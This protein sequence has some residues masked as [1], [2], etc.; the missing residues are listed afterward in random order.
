MRSWCRNHPVYFMAGYLVFYLAFFFLLEKSVQV[1]DLVLHCTLDDLIPFCKYA[2][3]PYYAWFAW[4]PATLFFLLRRGPRW[5]F[6][7]LC[8]PLFTGMTLALLFCAVVPNGVYLRPAHIPGTDVFARAVRELYHTDTPTNVFPSIHV[9]NAVTLDLAWQRRLRRD[10]IVVR[11]W[12]GAASH[13]LAAAIVA[14]TMLLKQHSAMDVM[15]GI[16]LAL[17]LDRMADGL[18]AWWY[19]P[20]SDRLRKMLERV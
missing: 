8:L 5:D 2:I 13:L 10:R 16:L 14:S 15:G 12:G 20:H 7:R 1:P 6:W 4:I 19:A 18:T 3:I 17:L 9:L 11:L